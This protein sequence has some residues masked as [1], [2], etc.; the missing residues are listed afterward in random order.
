MWFTSPLRACG[1]GN[2]GGGGGCCGGGGAL[3]EWLL[4]HQKRSRLS[5]DDAVLKE[6]EMKNQQKLC[7]CM[8]LISK[9]SLQ[10]MFVE[11]V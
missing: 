7:D 1:G 10:K 2:G 5:E 3:V 4:L 6:N 8:M 9:A 11:D